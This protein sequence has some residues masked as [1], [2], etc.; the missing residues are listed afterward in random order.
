MRKEFTICQ[1]CDRSILGTGGGFTFVKM[2]S[3]IEA[4]RQSRSSMADLNESDLKCE[5]GQTS[6]KRRLVQGQK[7]HERIDQSTKSGVPRAK[8]MPAGRHG[9][10][11]HA[12]VG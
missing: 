2:T 1:N 8:P 5:R 6:K 12:P 11:P 9:T 7:G 4:E 3:K 10:L